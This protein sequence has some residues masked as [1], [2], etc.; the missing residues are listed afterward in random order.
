LL[1]GFLFSGP[2]QVIPKN[3]WLKKLARKPGKNVVAL[4]APGDYGRRR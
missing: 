3:C 1:I 4:G 2:A